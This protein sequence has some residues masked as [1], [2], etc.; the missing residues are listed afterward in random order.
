LAKS[1]KLE[2]TG[3]VAKAAEIE[4]T[5]RLR[6]LLSIQLKKFQAKKLPLRAPLKITRFICG[7]DSL[8]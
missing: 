8:F 7:V 1:L 2:K 4:K 5:Q 6:K 3:G